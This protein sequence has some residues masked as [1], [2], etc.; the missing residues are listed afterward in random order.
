[1]A[2][3]T[4]TITTAGLALLQAVSNAGGTLEFTKTEAGDGVLGEADPAE[5]TAL[6][7]TEQTSAVVDVKQDA[8][9]EWYAFVEF[10]NAN[11]ATGYLRREMGLFARLAGDAGSETLL[12]YFHAADEEADFVPAA[13][14]GT[15]LITS[16]AVKISQAAGLAATVTLD[17]S[18]TYLPL[19]R[20]AQHLG[21]VGGVDQHPVADGLTYGLVNGAMLVPPGAVM[22]FA[23]P[24][25][26]AG[27]LE[28]NGA[29]VSR[30][31]Y[32]T[33]LEA[34]TGGEVSATFLNQG[35]NLRVNG[36]IFGL[37]M[38]SYTMMPVTFRAGDGGTL[39]TGITA[40]TEYR[41]AR[42]PGGGCIVFLTDEVTPVAYTDSGSGD[43]YLQ[44][45]PF[46]I[47]DGSTTFNVPDLRS[48][49]VRGFGGISA[50]N[51]LGHW[52][53]A[54]L[55]PVDTTMGV[56]NNHTMG[57]G[58]NGA[59]LHGEAYN[60]SDYPG[61]KYNNVVGEVPGPAG[62]VIGNLS[63]VP[64]NATAVHPRNVA[65]MYCIKY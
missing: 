62:T 63:D 44:A 20:W 22:P 14:S 49:F 39:P 57:I 26:P 59:A 9:G 3:Y 7:N 51:R 16:F 56:P 41:L 42:N 10:S 55:I 53:P 18:T 30:E 37:P 43:L 60:A 2:N 17:Q 46:G 27:W 21:G 40:N 36:I 29:A 11:V 38:T 45:F 23:T 32:A 52:Q 6:I 5:L 47:G 1:M 12:V 54:T 25:A 13:G 34:I 65:L 35:G 58:P 64:A 24:V 31:T 48:E 8:G 4:A 15:G 50:G 19:S 33:L 61:A 28:C